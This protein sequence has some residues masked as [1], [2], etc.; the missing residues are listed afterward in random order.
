MP[1][2][3]AQQTGAWSDNSL[4]FRPGSVES[5]TTGAA[6]W[7]GGTARTDDSG[8]ALSD[9]GS[10]LP[11]G[12]PP[13]VE[14]AHELVSALGG[15]TQVAARVRAAEVA[16]LSSR[17]SRCQGAPG[18]IGRPQRTQR[19]VPVERAAPGLASRPGGVPHSPLAW[20]RGEGRMTGGGSGAPVVFR[21]PPHSEGFCRTLQPSTSSV[22]RSSQIAPRPSATLAA[23][24]V[25]MS[26]TMMSRSRVPPLHTSRFPSG[27][28]V[29]AGFEP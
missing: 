17:R 13:R 23:R 26:T 12:H 27:D 22:R 18:G 5:S 19:T 16:A 1:N 14:G 15:S 2:A 3:D 6:V 24:P 20:P 11:R 9:A 29:P 8:G 7:H 4:R 28:H 21:K 10:A 25:A